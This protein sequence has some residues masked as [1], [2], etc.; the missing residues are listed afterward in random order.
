[1]MDKPL[2]ILLV[3]R[4]AWN[5]HLEYHQFSQFSSEEYQVGHPPAAP[6][7]SSPILQ[8]THPPAISS[9]LPLKCFILK[10]PMGKPASDVYE[11]IEQK[12]YIDI[13]F[14]VRKWFA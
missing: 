2:V 12:S 1:M 11:E 10:S 13:G 5:F 8:R 3:L 9:F 7:S 6:S 14:A 4:V